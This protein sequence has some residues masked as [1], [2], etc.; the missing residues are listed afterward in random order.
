MTIIGITS[1][2]I[3]VDFGERTLGILAFLAR[4]GFVV[5]LRREERQTGKVGVGVVSCA[6]GRVRPLIILRPGPAQPNAVLV[7]GEFLFLEVSAQLDC[8][9]WRFRQ[10]FF[11]FLKKHGGFNRLLQLCYFLLL[12]LAALNLGIHQKKNYIWERHTLACSN[13]KCYFFVCVFFSASLSV[14]LSY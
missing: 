12:F 8:T 5:R 7:L 6:V 13:R 14:I 1:V 10:F 3:S 2:E 11:P 9:P 4:L